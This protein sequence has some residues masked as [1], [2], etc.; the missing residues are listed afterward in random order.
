MNT[1]QFIESNFEKNPGNTAI[2]YGGETITFAQLRAQ[3]NRMANALRERGVGKGCRVAFWERNC[4]EAIVVYYAVSRLNAVFIPLNYDL[5]FEST[6]EMVRTVAP[7]VIFLGENQLGYTSEIREEITGIRMLVSVHSMHA[8]I[9]SYEQLTAAAGES[10]FIAPTEG[11]EMNAIVFTSGITGPPK[12]AAFSHKSFIEMVESASYSPDSASTIINVPIYHISGMKG[13]MMPFYNRRRVI[14][15]RYLFVEDW[16]LLIEKER[17]ENVFIPPYFLAKVLRSPLFQKADLSSLRQVKY[18][19]DRISPNIVIDAINSFPPHTSFSK[20]YGLTEALFEVASL[21]E[22]EHKPPE[23]RIPDRLDSLGLPYP[24]VEVI[25]ANE[26]GDRLPPYE[27]GELLV[28][29]TR[30]TMGYIDPK[31]HELIPNK[32]YWIYTS[33]LG[34]M[35]E[36]GYLY[37]TGER[38]ANF[39]SINRGQEFKPKDNSRINV[40]AV[41][42]SDPGLKG[43]LSMF[44]NRGSQQERSLTDLPSFYQ[45]MMLMQ[46]LHESLDIDELTRNYLRVVPNLVRADDYGIFL[47]PFS[48]LKEMANKHSNWG[49]KWSKPQF[50]SIPILH[51]HKAETPGIDG[52]GGLAIQNSALKEYPNDA[53]Q[54][55]CT[56]LFS[57]NLDVLGTLL[58]KRM[59]KQDAFSFDELCIIRLIA[60]HM[61]LSII[62]AAQHSALSEKVQ[63]ADSVLNMVGYPI[64]VSDE[65]GRATYTNYYAEQLMEIDAGREIVPF[66]KSSIETINEKALPH[67]TIDFMP[68]D[69]KLKIKTVRVKNAWEGGKKVY[70]SVVLSSKDDGLNFSCFSDILNS[71]EIDVLTLA[72]QGFYNSEIARTLNISVNTVKFHLKNLFT[73]FDVSTRTELIIQAYNIYSSKSPFFG[74]FLDS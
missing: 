68:K 70:L 29:T 3:I 23:N 74:L 39:V 19:G 67:Y 53:E 14:L 4:P 21:S 55:L 49:L 71:R 24:D 73:K 15:M 22:E 9:L 31:T 32:D 18:G 16:L 58:F 51:T 45:I 11:D 65:D 46:Q 17:V 30:A 10:F 1:N 26:K 56:P 37:H 50:D 34:Y 35:D 42:Q 25:I 44:S 47:T 60:N 33:D 40:F 57:S 41:I 6:R 54:W 43:S 38:L 2:V 59:K 8:G 20:Q 62:N 64:F 5:P 13:I 48:I 69:A 7:E 12:A 28:H 61:C 52:T 72:A 63:M 27:V 36:K 66:I